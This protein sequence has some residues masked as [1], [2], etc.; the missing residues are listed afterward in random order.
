M[1]GIITTTEAEIEQKREVKLTNGAGAPTQGTTAGGFSEVVAQFVV[2]SEQRSGI[3]V[4]V[5][6][7]MVQQVKP[8]GSGRIVWTRD[9]AADDSDKSFTVP[10][11]KIWWVQSVY[12]SITTTATAGNRKLRCCVYDPTNA[13]V[14]NYIGSSDI[15]ASKVSYLNLS[16]GGPASAAT[17]LVSLAGTAVDTAGMV[18]S[19]DNLFLTAGYIIRC[20]D[21]AAIAAAADDMIVSIH[22]IEYDA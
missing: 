3:G 16:L 22:Y 1:V 18:G 5:P 15:A 8:W 20:W 19:L 12:I 21:F 13:I 17:N 6:V 9:A 4:T 7:Q 10:D 11:G 2:P 14:A